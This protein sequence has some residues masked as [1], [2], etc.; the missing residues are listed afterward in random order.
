M[1]QK[2]ISLSPD[3]KQLRD[4][5][6]EIEVKNSAYAFVHNVPYV[7]ANREIKYGMLVSE[8]TLSGDITVNP[9]GQHVIH[10]VGEHPC[11]IHGSIIEGIRHQSV[12]QELVDG[13]TISH[14]F[15]NRPPNGYANYYDKFV[16]YIKIISAP[17]QAL[18]PSVTA[19]TFRPIESDDSSVF[20]YYDTNASRANIVSISNKLEGQKIAIVGLG[21]TGAYILDFVAKTPVAEIHLFDGDEFLS[22]NAFRSPGAASK[23]VLRER[24]NKAAHYHSVYSNMHKGIRF[25]PEFL[26]DSN[27]ETILIADFVFVS[28]D[29]GSEKRLIIE[30]LLEHKKPFIDVGI[31]VHIVAGSLMGQIRVTAGNEHKRDHLYDR[32]SFGTGGDDPYSTNIQIAELNAMNAALAVIR[33][34]KAFGFYN[35]HSL[36]FNTI[37][38][39]YTGDLLNEDCH[40]E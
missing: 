34:K 18:D 33:W 17:A 29:V 10:F 8:L 7:N 35:N 22:H 23:Q 20:Q 21:G 4:E 25:Y 11:D 2:L 19:Q 40:E 5:G 31:G 38:S 16:Q 28:I 36:E 24:R 39:T 6:Y 3:L 27:I 12:N 15:S 30:T 14:S 1:S 13:V 37:Y 9:L 26:T 32:I